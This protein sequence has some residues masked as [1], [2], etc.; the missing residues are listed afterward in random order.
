MGP[1]ADAGPVGED[2][3][4][5]DKGVAGDGVAYAIG[6]D[7]GIAVDHDRAQRGG[8]SQHRSI[9][10][11]IASAARHQG[12]ACGFVDRQA[13]LVLSEGMQLRAIGDI[14]RSREDLAGL[15]DEGPALLRWSA[16]EGVGFMA[17]V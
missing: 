4:Q 5:L 13:H 12:I 15:E 9:G 10:Q 2:G 6:I 17:Q 11:Q 16:R 3:D 8:R 1:K 7:R 14:G